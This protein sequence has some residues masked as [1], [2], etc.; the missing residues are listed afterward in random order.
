MLHKKGIK[1]LQ[2]NDVQALAN[3]FVSY[4]KR[5]MNVVR[6]PVY[7]KLAKMYSP[8]NYHGVLIPTSNYVFDDDV[9]SRF[10]KKEYES[11]EVKAIKKH[12][13]EK[14]DIVDLGAST[15]FLTT[16]LVDMFDCPPRAV[17][18]E[19]NKKLI[20]ILEEVKSLN[21]VDFE[22]EDSAYHSHFERVN[23]NLHHLTVG[24]SVQRE[25]D[26]KEVVSAI[27]LKR[28]IQ[29]Y[30]LEKFICVVDIEGGEADLINN[31]LDVLEENCKLLFVEFHEGYA[32]GVR[33]AKQSLE[34]SR[35]NMVD[36]VDGI[37][38]Y[39]SNSN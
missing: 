22:I 39:S 16:Y 12:V 14:Y 13:E 24:G 8:I 19:A 32:H 7:A 30:E 21:G 18:V 29:K 6:N 9:R 33:D 23:F 4:I 5:K 34:A 20:P 1:K 2:K 25:T 3:R 11:E 31:E 36:K 37:H 38:V 28:I 27:S 26:N 15:G 10:I 35:L 17:A